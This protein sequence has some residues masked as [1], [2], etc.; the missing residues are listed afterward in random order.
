MLDQL[1]ELLEM[2]R[3]L[4]ESIFKEHGITEYPIENMK[5]ALFDELGELLH[6]FPTKYKHWKKTAVDNREKGLEEYVDVL[7]FALSLSNYQGVKPTDYLKYDRNKNN[8]CEIDL[9]FLLMLVYD[10]VVYERGSRTLAYL[11]ALGNYFGF[12]WE[13]IYTT[14]KKKNEVNYQRL[15]SGY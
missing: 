9:S 6:E 1:K 10:K 11:F 13:E 3:V 7:H 2:Q 5:L 15:R 4:D 8:I 14:Y 12:E